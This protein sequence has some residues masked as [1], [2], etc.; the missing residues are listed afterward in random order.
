MW[1][2]FFKGMSLSAGL[3]LSI[4]SQNAHVLRIGIRREHVGLTVL[5]CILCEAVLILFGVAGMGSLISRHPAALDAAR[6]GGA[7]FLTWYGWRAWRAAWQAQ[8]LRADPRGL[9][10]DRRTASLAVLAVTL[11]N[12]HVYLDTVILLG[13]V[14]AQQGLL[15]QYWFAAGAICNAV[16]WF[17][18]LGFGARWLAPLFALPRAWQI[19]DVGV[20]VLMWG[21]ALNLLFHRLPL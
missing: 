16:V 15:G 4:G 19:L 8:T 12:P 13:A 18:A 10:L 17:L 21:L 6:F 14:A 20:A 5:I 2:F 11:L 3:I 1:L 7:A 9:K